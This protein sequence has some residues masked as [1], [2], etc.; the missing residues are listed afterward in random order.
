MANRPVPYDTSLNS[1]NVQDDVLRKMDVRQRA[2]MTF[3]LNDNVR[4][5]VE[6]GVR[7]RHPEYDDKMVVMAVT[8]LMIGDSLFKEAFGDIELEP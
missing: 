2:E 3:E 5:A 8:K 7:S 6:A 1:A 4:A